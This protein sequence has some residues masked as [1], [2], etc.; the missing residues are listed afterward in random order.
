MLPLAGALPPSD[1]TFAVGARAAAALPWGAYHG[2]NGGDPAEAQRVS[3]FVIEQRGFASDQAVQLPLWLDLGVAFDHRF[4]FGAFASLGVVVPRGSGNATGYDLRVGLE[5][6]YRFRARHAVAPWVGAGL[7]IWEIDTSFSGPELASAQ[8][9]VDFRAGHHAYVGPFAAFSV[10]TFQTGSI[11]VPRT[12]GND[13]PD[14]A[15]HGWA[16]LGVRVMF[17]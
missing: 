16:F 11:S 17:E 8:A 6:T 12:V 9:G 4:F 3:G 10:A 13:H 1:A 15:L 14:A 5:A 2:S 7:G